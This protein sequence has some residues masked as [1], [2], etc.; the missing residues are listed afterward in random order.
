[1]TGIHAPE[2]VGHVTNVYLKISAK[3]GPSSAWIPDHMHNN[4]LLPI[5]IFPI[6]G[7]LSF[8]KCKVILM[9]HQLW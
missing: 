5:E 7:I 9:L 3:L 6:E 8:K 4:C 2:S 1:M